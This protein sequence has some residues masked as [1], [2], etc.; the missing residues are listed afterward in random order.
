MLLI[1]WFVQAKWCCFRPHLF[2]KCCSETWQLCSQ[3]SSSSV[4][5]GIYVIMKKVHCST[6]TGNQH[7]C[8]DW[9][10]KRK[11]KTLT[12]HGAGEDN[13]VAWFLGGTGRA[14]FCCCFCLSAK[15]ITMNSLCNF[16]SFLSADIDCVRFGLPWQTGHISSPNNNG[17]ELKPTCPEWHKLC[18]HHPGI[19]TCWCCFLHGY[20]SLRWWW[21]LCFISIS[22]HCAATFNLLKTSSFLELFGGGRGGKFSINSLSLSHFPFRDGGKAF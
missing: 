4:M 15:Q 5:G 7:W 13:F 16:L 11:K 9:R 8:L 10:N 3:R 20:L 22:S 18:C 2:I 21:G 1:P 19:T 17:A 14:F 6:P 12:L